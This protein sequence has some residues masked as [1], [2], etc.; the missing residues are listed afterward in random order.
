MSLHFTVN[1]ATFRNGPAWRLE[2]QDGPEVLPFAVHHRKA[3]QAMA[4]AQELAGNLMR[5][6]VT[7]EGRHRVVLP[8]KVSFARQTLQSP[9]P[10]R[11]A[12]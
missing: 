8:A 12:S 5:C 1:R 3:K 2:Q 7:V 4:Y 10:L 11:E 6:V 9:T